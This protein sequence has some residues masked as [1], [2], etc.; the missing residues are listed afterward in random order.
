MR[1]EVEQKVEEDPVV[2]ELFTK[3]KNLFLN[4]LYIKDPLQN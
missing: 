4:S 1:Q 3:K 2:E